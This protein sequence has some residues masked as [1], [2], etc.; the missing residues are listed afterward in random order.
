MHA[1]TLLAQAN[2]DAG[3]AVFGGAMA[4]MAFFWIIGIA[5]TIFW[6]WMLVDALANQ[7]TTEQKIL[8]FLVIFLLPVVGALIYLF[9]GKGGRTPASTV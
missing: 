3:A 8:W 9:V 7:P 6:L 1:L 5:F 4:F 2:P